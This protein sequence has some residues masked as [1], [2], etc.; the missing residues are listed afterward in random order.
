MNALSLFQDLK[1]RGVILTASPDGEH[2]KVD[3]P[4]GALTE[5][6]RA[7][8]QEF[9]P[10][11]LRILSHQAIQEPAEPDNDRRFE[12]R[13]SRHPGYTSLYDPIEGVWHDF[14]TKDCFPSILALA[15][16]HHKKGVP[17]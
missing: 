1:A 9:K 14:P 10:I 7:G 5:A 13:R 3:A 6:D 12:A 2:L 15:D 17:A 8:L 11:L 4:A 16:K